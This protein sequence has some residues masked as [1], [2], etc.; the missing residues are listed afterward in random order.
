MADF[1]VLTWTTTVCGFS[2]HL[3]PRIYMYIPFMVWITHDHVE[4]GLGIVQGELLLCIEQKPLI[5]LHS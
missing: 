4:G 5:N 2:L 1:E 3:K